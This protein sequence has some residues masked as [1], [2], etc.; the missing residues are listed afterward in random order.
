M[1]ISETGPAVGRRFVEPGDPGA[2]RDDVILGNLGLVRKI[3]NEFQGRGLEFDDLVHEGVIGLMHAAELFDPSRGVKF[4]TYATHAVRRTIIR[5]VDD[6]SA[7]RRGPP[8]NS[9]T[10]VGPSG[11]S[12]WRRA[13]RRA[14]ARSPIAWG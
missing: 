4:G 7:S 1:K 11:T 2:S 13:G 9:P 6:K 8:A 12:T 14:P 10:G 5:A 3:A